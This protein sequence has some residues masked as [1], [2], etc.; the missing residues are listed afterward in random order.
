MCF[1]QTTPPSLETDKR[2]LSS[3]S[4]A[5]PTSH[6]FLRDGASEKCLPATSFPS[7][8]LGLHQPFSCGGYFPYYRTEGELCISPALCD[9]FL[10]RIEMLENEE[11]G[12]EG[13]TRIW[14]FGASC[15]VCWEQSSEF[16][17]KRQRLIQCGHKWEVLENY[18]HM[19]ICMSTE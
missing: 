11:G 17:S 8:L 12:Q 1:F 18:N 5:E 10:T 9:R 14:N 16:V 3:M 19:N 2:A 7:W 6:E 4:T 13:E 15:L